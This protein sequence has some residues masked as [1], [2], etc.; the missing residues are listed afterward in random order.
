MSP[1]F[2]VLPFAVAAAASAFVSAASAYTFSSGN[3]TLTESQDV[4]AFS[5]L[6]NWVVSTPAGSTSTTGVSSTAG[7]QGYFATWI[8]QPLTS[9]TFAADG[10]VTD[11]VAAGSALTIA[12]GNLYSTFSNI[13]V[14]LV[15]FELLADISTQSTNYG[16]QK[17]FDVGPGVT[18]VTT[19]QDGSIIID[20]AS[21]SLVANGTPPNN[22]LAPWF[23]N[24]APPSIAAPTG[25][26]VF[27]SLSGKV[28][29][30][31]PEPSTYV[32]TGLGLLAASLVSRRH[33]A[34][35]AV[36]A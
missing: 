17:L 30:A 22:V 31:V 26:V 10:S 33:R 6:A 1:S 16:R 3:L 5:D 34:A 25:P 2:R 21:A 28:T 11:V 4:A 19:L 8:T 20:L 7:D 12:R 14:N 29:A 32:I 9:A 15:T 27:G 35:A 13:E 36:S 18:A 24:I 23:L